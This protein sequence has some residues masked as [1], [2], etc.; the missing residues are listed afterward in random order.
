[1]Y[2]E[3][4]GDEEFIKW[5]KNKTRMHHHKYRQEVLKNSYASKSRILN[6]QGNVRE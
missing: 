1:M 3:M 6:I 4:Y 2:T 5:I